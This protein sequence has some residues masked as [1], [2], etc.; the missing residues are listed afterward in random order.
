VIDAQRF[1]MVQERRKAARLVPATQE[2]EDGAR[3]DPV[4]SVDNR[5]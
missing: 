2:Q 1:V 4:G 3:F 5:G